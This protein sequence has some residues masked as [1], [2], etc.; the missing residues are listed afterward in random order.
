M[1]LYDAEQERSFEFLTNN[2]KL[3]SSTMALIYK[4]RLA[5]DFFTLYA[6][7]KTPASNA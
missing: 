7:R 3:A 4:D 5:V 2:L 1:T 6:S